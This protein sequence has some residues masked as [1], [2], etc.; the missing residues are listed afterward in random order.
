VI[1]AATIEG[2]GQ[3]V[4][5][6]ALQDGNPSF[7][8]D[9]SWLAFESNRSGFYQM[10]AVS[11]ASEKTVQLTN[12]G[13][14]NQRRPAWAPTPGSETWLVYDTDRLGATR[15]DL[16]MIK[17]A[18]T[19]DTVRVVEPVGQPD[20]PADTNPADDLA[21][22]WSHTS[23]IALNSTRSVGG[24]TH[25]VT[26]IDPFFD[27]AAIVVNGT[28][29]SLAE[30]F[31]PSFSPFDA[32]VAFTETVTGDDKVFVVPVLGS[33]S[34]RFEVAPGSFGFGDAFDPAW[35]PDGSRIAFV[36][37]TTGIEEIWILE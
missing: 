23:V 17:V 9:G 27:P 16:Y 22:A 3:Q 30:T 19:A 14:G 36:S 34:V 1:P 24:S 33:G 35:S 10:F 25:S 29:Q 37:T 18:V 6:G 2:L 31:A 11:L 7:S 13:A 20:M 15:R 4:T 32:A 8:S 21:P 12:V 28:S 5:S 26:L